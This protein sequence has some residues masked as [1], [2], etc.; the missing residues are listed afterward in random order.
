MNKNYKDTLLMPQTNFEMRANLTIKEP[1]LQKYWQDQKIY[2]QL[3][4]KNKKSTKTF[5]LHDGPPYANGDLHL[6]HALNKILKDIIVRYYNSSNYYTPYIAG[7]DT[8]GLPIETAVTNSGINRKKIAVSDF[9]KQCQKYVELQVANQ[10]NQFKTLGLLTDFKDH[11]VTYDK[12]YESEQIK[13]FS[14]MV[15]KKLVYRNLYPV[16]WSPSSESALAEAEVEYLTKTSAAIY[17]AFLLNDEKK[18]FNLPTS[19]VIWTTTPWTIPSNQMLAVNEEFIY[20]IIKTNEQQ[21]IIAQPLIDSFTKANNITDFTI[22]KTISG[23]DLIGLTA[24]HPLYQRKT[25]IVHGS[26]VTINDGT[27]IVHTAPAFGEED[28][29]LGLKHNIKI[30]CPIN[31]QGQFTAEINDEQL[32]NKFYDDT[33]KIIVERLKNNGTLI[34]M[35]WFKHQY[36]HDWRTKKPVI[37]R[38]TLQWF[39]AIEKI[40]PL[41]TKNI[42]KVNFVPEWAKKRMLLMTNNRYDWCISRQRAWGLPIP[43]FYTKKKEPIMDIN[44]INHVADLFAKHGSNIWFEKEAKDLLPPKYQHK[45]SPNGIFYKEQDIM[46]VWYDS[47]VSHLAVIKNNNLPWPADLY[48]EGNDQFRGWFNSS[49]TTGTITNNSS[50]YKNLLAHGFVTDAKGNKM[51]KSIGNVISVKSICDTNGADILRLWVASVDFTDDTRIGTEILKQ[52]SENYRKIR[53]IFRFLL[54]NLFDLDIKT[55]ENKQQEEIINSLSEVDQYILNKLN[56]LVIKINENYQTYQF[57]TI[58]HLILNFVTNDLSAFYC[59]FTKDILYVNSKND[60]R[61]KQVQITMFLIVKTLIGLLAPIL[62]HTTEEA[63][64]SLTKKDLNTSSD[65]IHLKKFPQPWNLNKATKLMEKWEY[66]INFKNEV[67]KVIEQAKK[68]KIVKTALETI[69]TII[70]KDNH[71]ILSTI[72]EKELAQLLI[73]SEVNIDYNNSNV[74]DWTI[75][76]KTKDGTKCPRCWL[77]V[78]ETKEDVCNRCFEVLSLIM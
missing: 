17:V 61:R 13:V 71:N 18:I 52:V 59:D 70:F 19:L 4:N 51:S 68:D 56:G 28:F 72:D 58:Y 55:I 50:P 49:L 36:P 20:S 15:E 6:G 35:K 29:D 54:G 1:Q 63:F 16:Y 47:G 74:N 33:N 60:I 8:H 48:L 26:H 65:S 69:V 73:V 22:V 5:I 76:V 9:R 66:F 46:D 34:G 67:N 14:K 10:I 23:K 27:G 12:K 43:I 2:Q 40:K 44:L 62:P 24:L 77:I 30:L 25:P 38:A 11:Y 31:D 57:N 53:N 75:N 37:Y 42:N 39:I 7:W 41:L 78:N 3:I 64:Q 32:V 45:D 21:Y